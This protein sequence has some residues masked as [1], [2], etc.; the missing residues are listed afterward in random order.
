MIACGHEGEVPA[1]TGAYGRSDF[2]TKTYFTLPERRWSEYTQASSTSSPRLHMQKS[3][4]LSKDRVWEELLTCFVEDALRKGELTHTIA[5]PNT[6]RAF[7]DERVLKPETTFMTATDHRGYLLKE[8]RKQLKADKQ[9]FALLVFAT[10]LEHSINSIVEGQCRRM[11]VSDDE[12]VDMLRNTPM[13]GKTTWLLYL[14]KLPRLTT[15]TRKSIDKIVEVRNWFVHY[16]WKFEDIDEDSMKKNIESAASKVEK[17]VK[18]LRHYER[19]HIIHFSRASL[20][21][22]VRSCEAQ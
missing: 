15:S 13:K 4:K 3:S 21:R 7:L 5:D 11:G 22:L 16:K 17:I 20:R 10:W 9:E 2:S 18:D 1:A 12:I 8:T 6:L 19:K 14:L